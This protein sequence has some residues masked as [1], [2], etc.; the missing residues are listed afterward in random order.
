[1]H[2]KILLTGA[3]FSLLAVFIGA[4]GA[5]ALSE[6]LLKNGRVATFETAVQYQIFHALALLVLGILSTKKPRRLLNYSAILF[7]IGILIFSG[8]LYALS[9]TEVTLLGAITPFGGLCF[10]AGWVLLIIFLAKKNY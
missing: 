4:F 5:H 6:I 2:K 8:S 7:S 9:I 3:V 10:I 1:M